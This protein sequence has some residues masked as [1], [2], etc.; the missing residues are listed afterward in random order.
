[1]SESDLRKHALACMRLS[2]DCMQL[3]GNVHSPAWQRHFLEMA[4]VWTARAER[5]LSV[6]APTENST[7]R[8]YPARARTSR[9]RAR[10]APARGW[11]SP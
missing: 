1:V 5:G 10:S 7:K 8:A 2:A 4:R 6:D 3:V 9:Q 11:G